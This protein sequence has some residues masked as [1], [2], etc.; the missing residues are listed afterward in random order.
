[1]DSSQ[2]VEFKYPSSEY[3]FGQPILMN[4]VY[5]KIILNKYNGN[6]IERTM[7]GEILFS[8]KS[9]GKW[10]M[11]GSHAKMSE[12]KD[13]DEFDNRLIDV[14]LRE[15]DDVSCDKINLR[16]ALRIL[17]VKI[18]ARYDIQFNQQMIYIFGE[19]NDD[20]EI[21]YLD[22][23]SNKTSYKP[24]MLHDF[25]ILSHD[26]N[27]QHATAQRGQYYLYFVYSTS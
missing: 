6:I 24:L 7:S 17:T 10:G 4:L 2:L 16:E 21:E 13:R 26:G 14:S 11:I 22:T 5:Y 9:Y 1:M 20:E 8:A 18:P 23:N 19:D 25:R 12:F 3:Y 27:F 15:T